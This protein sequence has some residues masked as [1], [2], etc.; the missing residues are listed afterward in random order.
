MGRRHVRA[1][2][3]QIYR[4]DLHAAS[5]RERNVVDVDAVRSRLNAA[6]QQS[7]YRHGADV[8]TGA[9]TVVFL[10]RDGGA[11]VRE[12]ADRDA[13]LVVHCREDLR[14]L[15]EEVEALRAVLA[16]G[17]DTARSATPELADV[18]AAAA[19]G[20]GWWTDRF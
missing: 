10:G 7:W 17:A 1:D 15:I 18:E 13:E 11:G 5:A 14:A 4:Y 19:G 2:F 9:G 6:D 8:R 20:D 3:G 16:A 12:Q